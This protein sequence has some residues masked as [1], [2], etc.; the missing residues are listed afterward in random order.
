LEGVLQ[1][2]VKKHL[3]M[4]LFEG[5]SV[6][7]GKLVGILTG[8]GVTLA[9]AIGLA[10]RQGLFHSEKSF[11]EIPGLRVAPDFTLKRADGKIVRLQ[12]LEGSVVLIHFWAAWCA[13]CIPE[14]PE[15][16]AA[17]RKLPK[18]KDGKPIYWLMISQDDSFEKAQKVLKD[19][20]LP[21]NVFSLLDPG[22]KVSD[23]FGSY[24][25]P[26]TYLI[27]REGGVLT[28]WIGSQEWNANWGEKVLQEIEELSRKGT[29]P[30]LPPPEQSG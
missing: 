13:P 24:Q 11:K 16:L 14:V 10:D 29:L 12:D 18:N 9:I 17:A 19:S 30:V 7:K 22:A 25:F 28:K 4:S 1:Y 6:R 15:F 8:F 20:D 3:K 5:N 21:E 27:T 2:E 26:E 23:L